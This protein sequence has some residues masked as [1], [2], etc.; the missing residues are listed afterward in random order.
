M[1]WHLTFP[2]AS[3]PRK[4]KRE[5]IFMTSSLKWLTMQTDQGSCFGDSATVDIYVGDVVLKQ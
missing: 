3:D 1:T 2:R 5:V 4:K